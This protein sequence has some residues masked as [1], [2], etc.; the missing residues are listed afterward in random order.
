METQTDTGAIRRALQWIVTL[1]DS[2][3]VPY[4]IVGGLAAQA[5]GATRPLVDIDLYIDMDSAQ[6]AL[7]AMRPYR[8]REALPHHSASWDLI[9]LALEYDGV[10]I[11]I[12]DTSSN[13]RFFNRVDQ[14]WEPQVIHYAASQRATLYGM[15]V[16]VM[17][18]DELIQYKA[19]LNR[20]VDTIDIQQMT[21]AR[22]A[23]ETA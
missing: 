14:R 15:A 17:P 22:G 10:T 11:E 7:A 16:S 18:R 4:Q 2:H 5:Y 20:E 13:P 12:G 23:P 3:N 21:A 1:L 9:Y 8:V 19:M 6:A